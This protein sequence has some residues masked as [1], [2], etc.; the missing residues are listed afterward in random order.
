[1]SSSDRTK[2]CLVVKRS[3]T[4]RSEPVPERPGLKTA[5]SENGPDWPIVVGPI[6]RKS[7]IEE[8]AIDASLPGFVNTAAF[9]RVTH[10]KV[11]GIDRQADDLA[12]A[13]GQRHDAARLGLMRRAYSSRVGP[14]ETI[15]TIP[16][17]GF[18][19]EPIQ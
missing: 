11:M 10:R 16:I 4:Q 5:I 18:S 19:S 17:C 9:S 6:E 2:S 3:P 12:V 1:M 8:V 7:T 13:G 14:L 15:S